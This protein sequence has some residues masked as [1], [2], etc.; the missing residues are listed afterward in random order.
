MG[1]LWLVECQNDSKRKAF[2]IQK[3]VRS[4]LRSWYDETKC[5]GAGVSG[6]IAT[7]LT[8]SQHRLKQKC[9]SG[10]RN[11]RNPQM[12]GLPL[13]FLRH[14]SNRTKDDILSETKNF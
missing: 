6:K 4:P 12:K 9:A 14:I 11:M 5:R 7:P 8:E 2:R 10:K 1:F 3:I 13:Q